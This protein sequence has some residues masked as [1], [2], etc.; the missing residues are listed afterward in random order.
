MKNFKYK[1]IISLIVFIAVS[2]VTIMFTREND[3][4]YR[5][6]ENMSGA[7]L[8]LVYMI[9]EEGN[10]FNPL[11][12]YVNA[13]DETMLHECVTPLPEDRKLTIGIGTYGQKITGISYEIRSLDG[14]EFL[15]NTVVTDFSVVEREDDAA[16]DTDDIDVIAINGD[17]GD[18]VTATLEIK[19]LLKKDTQYMLKI[20]VST[21]NK[22]A[23]YYTRI[24]L[25]DKLNLD[26]KIN[27]V[28]HFSE[29]TYDPSRI[30][31]II[32]KLEP[33][34]TGDN[35]NL[36]HVNIHSKL[37]QVGWGELT[38]SI[39][40][41]VWPVIVEIKGATADI[42]LDY[43]ITTPATRGIDIYEVKEFFRIKRADANT[44]YVLSYDRYV[45]QIFDGVDD[46]NDS[47]RIYMGISSDLYEENL[48]SDS[49][50]KVTCFT[51]QGE[52]WSYN[53]KTNAFTQI[54]TFIDDDSRYDSIRE[55]NRNHGIKVMKIN[56]S[57][58]V[59]FVVY[60][61][62]NRGSHEGEMG[63]SVFKYDCAANRVEELL[64][65][66]RNE[67][68]ETI[69][70][71][72]NTLVYLSEDGRFYM[73][74]GGSIYSVHYET[75]EYMVVTNNI[76]RDNSYF[77]ADQK[78]F[79]YQEGVDATYSDTINVLELENGQIKCIEADKGD[80]LRV[81]GLIDGNFI[82]GIAR[83]W[84]ICND[85]NDIEIF[86]MYKLIILNEK[87]EVA[88][89]YA[90][91][92]VRIVGIEADDTKIT[93][94]RMRLENLELVETGDDQLLSKSVNNDEGLRTTLVATEVRQKE[95]YIMLTVS[96]PSSQ[97]TKTVY[98]KS[99][100]YDGGSI[101]Y[102]SEVDSSNDYFR[103]YGMGEYKLLTMNLGEAISLADE[104]AGIVVDRQGNTIWNRYKTSFAKVSLGEEYELVKKY[105]IIGATLEESLYYIDIGKVLRVKTEAGYMLVYAYD[106]SNVTML[107]EEGNILVYSKNDFS[108][109]AAA[110]DNTIF[111]LD[112]LK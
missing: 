70:K 56:S 103:V 15:E 106:S 93:I 31:E 30:N 7:T 28:L 12:G 75:K 8:P 111:V 108:K 94:K 48:I 104:W 41:K 51:A 86:P 40:G 47:G 42:R 11:Y 57:G 89:T 100:E 37:S 26:A 39:Y 88:K 1:V 18:I 23:N 110:A 60:G 43:Q 5:R 53:S 72:I 21:G 101:M 19:N 69:E 34:S 65:V 99:V 95:K 78:V 92:N 107:N 82:Y 50:G 29:V 109:K 16:V 90:I 66:P 96:V 32:P 102:M 49:T 74:Q 59:F 71:D 22:T 68:F 112:V 98:P 83:E 36:G 58:D 9:S 20:K 77:A 105:E 97:E 62:M 76:I 44:T 73:Y 79:I 80:V 13:F 4:E 54:F 55:S 27:Y 25:G 81:L 63:V 24:V 38:P 10:E 45:D 87:L 67:V 52:L 35:T 6:K 91:N 85:E 3:S 84:E 17:M 14:K 46:L 2:V 61:Y 64:Y 33:N